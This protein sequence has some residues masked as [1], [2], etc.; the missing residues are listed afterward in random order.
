MTRLLFAVIIAAGITGCGPGEPTYEQATASYQTEMAILDQLKQDRTAL[1]T[2]HDAAVAS[3]YEK[4]NKTKA[5]I[6][7]VSARFISTDRYDE[8]NKVNSA[9]IEHQRTVF[10]RMDEMKRKHASELTPLDVKIA[11]QQSR[12]DEAEAKRE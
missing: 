11:D 4:L 10:A 9:F 12:V 2:A 1:I 3:E 7:S 8:A 5:D 6:A